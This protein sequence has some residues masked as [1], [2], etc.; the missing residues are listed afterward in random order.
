M[1]QTKI[2]PMKKDNL[3][4]NCYIGLGSNLDNPVRQV[5]LAIKALEQSPT[6]QLLQTSSLYKTEPVGY[7]AQPDFINAVACVQTLLSPEQLLQLLQTIELSQGRQRGSIQ[8]GPRTIDLDLLLYGEETIQMEQLTVP[9]PRMLTRGFV[10]YPLSEIAPSHEIFDQF[11][12]LGFQETHAE[13]E[14][15]EHEFV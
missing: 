15:L 12:W 4:I 14:K 7:A 2:V 3:L 8:F 10:L 1:K 6:I 11:D 5:F 13:P 9:H